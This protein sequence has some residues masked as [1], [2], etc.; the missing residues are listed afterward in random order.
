MFAAFLFNHVCAAFVFICAFEGTRDILNVKTF[1][2]PLCNFQ[3]GVIV[4]QMGCGYLKKAPQTLQQESRF[5]VYKSGTV[6][7]ET[8]PECVVCPKSLKWSLALPPLCP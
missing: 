8:G 5:E 6:S 7:T 3:T 1:F 4:T 2:F